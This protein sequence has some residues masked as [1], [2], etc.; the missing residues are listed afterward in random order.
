[1]VPPL[2]MNTNHVVDLLSSTSLTQSTSQYFT[3]S[4]GGNPLNRNLN[5]KV[6]Y[7]Y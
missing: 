2:I 5:C 1:M 7:K 3:I 6:P 4:R